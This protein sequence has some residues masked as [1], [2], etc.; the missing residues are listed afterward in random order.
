VSE[1]HQENGHALTPEY[2]LQNDD[3]LHFG[4]SKSLAL[5]KKAHKSGVQSMVCGVATH[6]SKSLVTV[7]DYFIKRTL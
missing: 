6:Q 5:P 4:T 1:F 2:P 3:K 7:F